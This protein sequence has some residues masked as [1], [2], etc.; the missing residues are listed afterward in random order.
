MGKAVFYDDAGTVVASISC[1]K[2]APEEI[3][4]SLGLDCT[5]LRCVVG[6]AKMGRPDLMFR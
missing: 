4:M 6:Q 3:V 1:G 5:Y 2:H